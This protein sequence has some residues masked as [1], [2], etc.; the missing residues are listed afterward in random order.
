MSILSV[1]GNKNRTKKGN[2]KPAKMLPTETYPVATSKIMNIPK[3][4][5]AS[6]VNKPKVTPSNVATPFPP[7]NPAKTGNMCPN[8]T[9]MAQASFK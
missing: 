3:A 8:T 2:D 6:Y 4:H 5:K 9:A 1:G 7:L